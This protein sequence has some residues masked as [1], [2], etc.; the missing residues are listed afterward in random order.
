MKPRPSAFA[1]I[2]LALLLPGCATIGG[3]TSTASTV[4]TPQTWTQTTIAARPGGLDTAALADWWKR[5]NDPVL[6][7]LISDALA[8]NPDVRIALSRIAQARATRIVE[9]SGLLP[10]LSAGVSGQGSRTRDRRA[11]TVSESGNYS[12]SLDASW[13]I[14]L[15]GK[16]R[17]ALAA[18]DSDLAQ[19]EENFHASQVSLAAEAA[20][21]YVN[22]RSA[23]A[24]L[25][26]VRRSLAS[27]E[28]TTRLTRWRQDAGI[29][30]ILDTRQAESSL[31][32]ARASIPAL[33]QSASETRNQLA[34]LTGRTPG[35]LDALLASTERVPAA[36]D[37]LAVGIPA[38]TLRQRPDVRAAGHAVEAAS[39]RS[40]TARRERLP[41]LNLTGSL[42]IDAGE[43]GRLASPTAT[44]ASIA[45][46]LAAPIFNAGRIGANIRIQDEATRQA[47]IAYESTVL[48][49][50]AEVENALEAIRR[51][52]ER[53][54]SLER[55]AAASRE[56]D[57]L[58]RQQYEAGSIDF[59][60]VL[61][62]ER[63]LLSAEQSLVTTDADLSS[64]HIRLYKALGGGWSVAPST[65]AAASLQP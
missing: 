25:A 20:T 39:K 27:R 52:T 26:V 12:A 40:E 32:Q 15:F 14:D 23:E 44:I 1:I 42:G 59:L 62:A 53:R 45:G 57:T 56:A 9:K 31:E 21:A 55:A 5:F 8:H 29:G 63:T 11:D 34:V 46:G 41:S 24:Q 49:A 35:S 38:E 7:E 13:E 58:A 22:L 2:P 54:A 3:H 64:A 65:P 10:S 28:E 60:Q 18:A 51:Q 33:R 17:L 6:D 16:Q 19:T 30:D 48:D 43:L 37:D 4:A 61:D 47:L 36:P 50:L